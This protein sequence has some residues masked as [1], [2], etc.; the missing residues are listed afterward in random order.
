M[1]M[2]IMLRRRRS[3][4]KDPFEFP[5]Y[6]FFIFNDGEPA[7]MG[8]EN[9]GVSFKTLVDDDDP[10]PISLILITGEASC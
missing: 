6:K 4:E 9:D 10:V 3:A 5:D 1:R 2:N 8:I 7:G